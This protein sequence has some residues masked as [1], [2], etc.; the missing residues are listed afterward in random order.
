MRLPLLLGFFYILAR[1]LFD[2]QYYDIFSPLNLGIH[3]VGHLLF[4]FFGRFLNILGGTIFQLFVPIFGMVNFYRQKDFFAIALCFG[5]LSTSFFHIAPYIADARA[6][7]LPLV[8]PFGIENVVHDWNYLLNRMGILRFDAAL[9]FF[10]KCLAVL[11]MIACF[12]SGGWL[13]WQMK[14]SSPR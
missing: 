3:E 14:K 1:H 12:Y 7:N 4:S 8:A 2:S 10:V 13:L 6:M 9:G 5:W 11:S